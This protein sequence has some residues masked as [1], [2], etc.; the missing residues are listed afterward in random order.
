MHPG[1]KTTSLSE[2]R[3]GRRWSPD[4]DI[5]QTVAENTS[6]IPWATDKM[7]RCLHLGRAWFELT[8][9]SDDGIGLKW[10]NY[11]H[12]DEV[13]AVRRAFTEAQKRRSGFGISHHIAHVSGDHRPV[14]SIGLPRIDENGKLVGFTG[15]ICL[16][17]YTRR[18]DTASEAY[19]TRQPVLTPRERETLQLAAEGKTTDVI[20]AVLGIT[21]RTVDTHIANAGLKLGCLNRVH[22]VATAMRRNEI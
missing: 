10:M 22:T 11:M 19:P 16:L 5:F 18:V 6:Y 9:A 20:A 21:S 8:G 17:E 14:W 12:P 7:G 2:E 1:A 15:A 13:I 3:G 4:S